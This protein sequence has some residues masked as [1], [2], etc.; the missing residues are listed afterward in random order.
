MSPSGNGRIDL[1]TVPAVLTHTT[2]PKGLRPFDGVS[3][4]ECLM[5]DSKIEEHILQQF[6]DMGP[7][8]RVGV[9]IIN[10]TDRRC[11]IV[12]VDDED[13]LAEIA[14]VLVQCIVTCL[15]TRP[16][17]IHRSYAEICEKLGISPDDMR[18]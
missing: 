18:H 15:K 1:T 2:F 14:D 13:D 3:L 9:Q 12:E 6:L 4:P 16:V 7:E 5:A 10:L 8:D 11:I 17:K